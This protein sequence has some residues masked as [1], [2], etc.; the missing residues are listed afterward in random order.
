MNVKEGFSLNPDISFTLNMP[1][2]HH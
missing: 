1:S 2:E